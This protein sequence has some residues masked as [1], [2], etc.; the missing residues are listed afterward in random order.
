MST[1]EVEFG[2]KPTH[3]CSCGGNLGGDFPQLQAS[4]IPHEIRHAAILGALSSIRE[5]RG[6]VL[7]ADHNPVPLLNQVGQAFPGVF[8]VEYLEEGP[9]QWSVQFSR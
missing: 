3:Q 8:T 7:C 9:D 4:A 5:G 2:A 1:V 6:M